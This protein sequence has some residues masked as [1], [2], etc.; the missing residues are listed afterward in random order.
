MRPRFP[1]T[2]AATSA[3]Q[4]GVLPGPP[5]WYEDRACCCPRSPWSGAGILTVFTLAPLRRTQ[6]KK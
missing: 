4:A 3:P 2:G 5:A 6:E 1:V